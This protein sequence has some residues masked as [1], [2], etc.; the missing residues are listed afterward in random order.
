MVKSFGIEP[1]K[2]AYRSPWRRRWRWKR[3]ARVERGILKLPDG[4]IRQLRY[5]YL[6]TPTRWA[7]LLTLGYATLAATW[8]IVSGRFAAASSVSVE[9]LER[10]ETA[11]GVGYV[12][13]TAAALFFAARFAL[14]RIERQGR[15]VLQRER[16]DR[17][18]AKESEATLNRAQAVAHIG[19][20]RLDIPGNELTWSEEVFR[21]FGV[22]AGT[23]L[24]YEAFLAMVHPEDRSALDRAWAAALRGAPYDIEHRIIVDN[25]VRWL[26]ERAEVEFD[27]T[28]R[29]LGGVGTVQDITQ[30]RQ[31]EQE[32]R[33]LNTELEERVRT[34]TA[35]L[36]A[37]NRSK[38]ELLVRQQ[39]TAAALAEARER[40]MSIGSRVQQMLLLN[41]PPVDLPGLRIAALTIP[42]QR[43]DGDFYD[44]FKHERQCLDLIVADVMGKGIPAALLAA[45]TKSHF[46]EALCHLMSLSRDGKLPEPKEI[47]TLAHARMARHLIDLESFVTLCYVRLDMDRRVADLVDCGHTGVIHVAARSGRC[48]VLHG[49]NLPLGVRVGEIYDQTSIALEPGDLLL[50]YSDGVTETRDSGGEVFGAPRLVELVRA[51]AALEPQEL[52]DAVRS[53]TV[54]FARSERVTDDLTCV[55]IK[56]VDPQLPFARAELALRS[57]LKDLRRAREFVRAVCRD[58][59]GGPLDEDRA[60]QLELAVNEAA[61]NIMKHAY[62]GRGDQWIDVEAESYP[63]RIAILLH[64]LGDSFDPSSVPA[65]VLDGSR[66]SGFGVYLITASVDEAR[67]F[68]DERGRNCISLVKRRMA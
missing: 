22:P 31:A 58:L 28:G 8:I 33:T 48:D 68:R 26:R 38:D 47:V 7:A 27:A 21:L 62:R 1:A 10:L 18:R 44:F 36:E 66:E 16:A 17:N 24:T 52:V 19:S 41:R 5:T 30:R 55:A 59:P 60:A 57:D 35:E 45:A 32:I 54:A 42:S 12:L 29:A 23:A 53:A 64:H 39:S 3:D 40:E 20:W 15:E 25:Q 4:R 56:V 65:P 14:G 34:R 63:D 61:S 6:V 11:K 13:V 37:A 51:S 9:E 46:L 43:V 50:V 2:T 67:Y 49:D